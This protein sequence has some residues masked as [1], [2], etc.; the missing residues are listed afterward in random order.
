MKGKSFI[1][2]SLIL[3]LS[4]CGGSGDNVSKN[5]QPWLGGQLPV[6]DGGEADTNVAPELLVDFDALSEASFGQ[7][8]LIPVYSEDADGDE[9]TLSLYGAPDWLVWSPELGVIKGI[10]DEIGNFASFQVIAKDSEGNESEIVYS[11]QFDIQIPQQFT[12]DVNFPVNISAGDSVNM[13]FVD[14]TEESENIKFGA[15]VDESGVA[16]FEGFKPDFDTYE[17]RTLVVEWQSQSYVPLFNI[18]GPASII[19]NELSSKLELSSDAVSKMAPT[20]KSAAYYHLLQKYSSRPGNTHVVGVDAASS[21]HGAFA[22]KVYKD[23][24]GYYAMTQ[25]YGELYGLNDVLRTDLFTGY[26]LEV[27]GQKAGLPLIHEPVD[28][29][30]L[31]REITRERLNY[32]SSVSGRLWEDLLEKESEN[33][34]KY[35]LGFNV[36]P[37][38]WILTFSSSSLYGDNEGFAITLNDDDTSQIIVDGEVVEGSWEGSSIA[39]EHTLESSFEGVKA[40]TFTYS[41]EELPNVLLEL[42]M[43]ESDVSKYLE[44]AT[45]EGLAFVDLSLVKNADLSFISHY[46]PFEDISIGEVTVHSVVS[47]LGDSIE[48]TKTQGAHLT[49]SKKT[50]LDS[51][52]FDNS[53]YE[54]I[55]KLPGSD[56]YQWLDLYLEENVEFN[57]NTKNQPDKSWKWSYDEND[58]ALQLSSFDGSSELVSRYIIERE[59][60]MH[61]FNA[62]DINARAYGVR[63]IVERNGVV[64]SDSLSS[65]ILHPTARCEYY[66][67]DTP[68]CAFSVVQP[69]STSEGGDSF[70]FWFDTSL[71][72]LKLG[73]EYNGQSFIY[74][75]DVANAPENPTFSDYRIFNLESSGDCENG[76]GLCFSSSS[77]EKVLDTANY[78]RWIVGT[79]EWYPIYVTGN[80][81]IVMTESGKV[82]TYIALDPIK[83]FGDVTISLSW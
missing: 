77:N 9:V 31:E 27:N 36:T 34:I 41:I 59:P 10:V 64:I 32:D 38:E 23:M 18:V 49:K 78:D 73:T 14:T 17:D 40:D 71:G 13:Y 46:T 42:G 65:L 39:G 57:K 80:E 61:F 25:K 75:A 74:I 28:D 52:S 50:G 44:K 45:N 7:E 82:K 55:L 62:G 54:V 51:W 12:L 81:M 60:S 48:V 58:N 21:Y 16:K 83:M 22:G 1:A 72:A 47:I 79:E 29:I 26:E 63:N 33:A 11:P 8:V 70:K 53:I 6:D 43:D 3:A 76:N 2:L 37:G 5:E 56:E 15:L 4:G 35:G 24:V 30:A 69:S 19:K 67:D 20:V 68:P 66:T